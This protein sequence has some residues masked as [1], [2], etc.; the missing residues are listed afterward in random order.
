MAATALA[1]AAPAAVVLLGEDQVAFGRVVEVAGLK[2]LRFGREHR[3]IKG[4]PTGVK[5][6][7]QCILLL[8]P[9]I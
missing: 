4:K 8:K 2:R 7:S 5:P 3:G 9:P 6:T 1:A